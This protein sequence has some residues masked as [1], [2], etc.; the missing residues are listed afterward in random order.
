MIVLEWLET[1]ACVFDWI[2]PS[3]TLPPLRSP[4]GAILAAIVGPQGPAGP[5]GEPGEGGGGSGTPGPQGPQGEPGPQGPQGDVGP[6]GP[7]GPAGED[8]ALGPAGPQGIQGPQGEAGSDGVTGPVGPQGPQGIP[9]ETG[10]DGPIG[11][12][13]PIGP[14]GEAGPQGLQ[15]DVGPAGTAGADGAIGPAGPTGPQGPTGAEGPTGPAGIDG[16]DGAPG[17]TGATG[18]QGIQGDPGP[19]GATGP[20]GPEGPQG[21]QGVKGDTGDTGPA[22]PTGPTGPA[23]ADG[24]GSGPDATD[25]IAEVTASR[26][27]RSTLPKRMD[28]MSSAAS[29]NAVPV[30]IGRW[31]DGAFHA[32]NPGTLA[33]AANRLDLGPFF[34]SQPLRVDRVAVAVSTA[35][36]SALAKIVIYNS[37]DDGVPDALIYESGDI[38]CSSTGGKEITVDITFEANR[39]YWLGTRHSSTATLRTIV[40]SSALNMGMSSSNSSTM[41]S[42]LRRTVTFASAAPDPWNFAD[43][44]AVFAT[45]PSVRMRARSLT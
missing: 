18:S 9:G 17:A 36:A 25:V 3:D 26:G 20:A 10:E 27:G 13:G 4:S 22:G 23:G 44:D 38:D 45:P 42:C 12:Q 30:A 15:G 32:A 39:I 40:S 37:N 43:S 34:T 6:T 33:G 31:Y 21:I 5:Q 16:D 2:G 14:S 11:P 35:V 7:P 24:G 29:P 19:T 1:P 41:L 8:G 28:V